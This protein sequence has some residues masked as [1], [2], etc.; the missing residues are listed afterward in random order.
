MS[1][2]VGLMGATALLVALAVGF[3]VTRPSANAGTAKPTEPPP[4]VTSAASV[5]VAPPTVDSSAPV[6]STTPS[7]W[8]PP[9]PTSTAAGKWPRGKPTG[10]KPVGC[11]PPYEFD[12]EGKK[13]FKPECL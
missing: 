4:A 5:V 1:L 9:K 12:K 3:V 7:V 8:T 10:A 6:P 13:H 2:A 11:D